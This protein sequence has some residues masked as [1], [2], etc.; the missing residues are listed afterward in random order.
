MHIEMTD[1]IESKC[2]ESPEIERHQIEITDKMEAKHGESSDCESLK[3]K[4][5]GKIKSTDER[6][7]DNEN[8]DLKI[9]RAN[10]MDQEDEKISIFDCIKMCCCFCVRHNYNQHNACSYMHR[11]GNQRRNSY[12]KVICSTPEAEIEK[13]SQDAIA[14]ICKRESHLSVRYFMPPN[15]K[16]ILQAYEPPD[17]LSTI[18]PIEIQPVLQHPPVQPPPPPP[19]FNDPPPAKT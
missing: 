12:V 17:E 3:A 9:E 6:L 16:P 8:V 19:P 10:N 18:P 11:V 1:K 7:T 14:N 13:C 15:K 4:I 2:E 5:A